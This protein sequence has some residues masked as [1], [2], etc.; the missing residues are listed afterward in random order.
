MPTQALE[1]WRL[2]ARRE[3]KMISSGESPAPRFKD[4]QQRGAARALAGFFALMLLLTLLSRAAEGLTVARVEVAQPKTGVLTQRVTVN[5]V[6][7]AQGDLPITLPGGIEVLRVAAEKGQRVQAGGVLLEL[8]QAGLESG[9]E[10]L[11][12]GLKLLDLRI[13]AARQGNTEESTDALLSAQEAVESAEEA[14]RSAEQALENAREDHERLVQSRETAESREAEDLAQAR[15]DVEQAEANLEKAKKK[16]KEELEK[17][18]KEKAEAARETLTG[19]EESAAEEK[20]AAKETLD[21]ASQEQSSA[22]DAYWNAIEARDRADRLV[23]EAQAAL[24]K[25]LEAEAPDEQTVAA[26]QAALSQA[27]SVLLQI[28]S[29]MGSLSAANDSAGQAL[30]QAQESL[31][32]VNEKWEKELGKAKEALEKAEAELSEVQARSDMSEE[33]LVVS[34]QASLDSARRALRSAERM[35]ADTQVSTEDQLRSSL[36]GIETAEQNVESARRN[37][38][39]A[40]RGVDSALRQMENQ[41]KNNENARRQAEIEE[42]G[43]LSQRRELEESIAALEQAAAAGGVVTAPISGT[44]FSILEEP[45][46]TQEG[47]RVALLSRSDLGFQ[48]TGKLTE[49]EAGKLSVGDEG[50]L[51]YQQDG[52][53][54]T[55]KVAITGI[56]MADE[57]GMVQVTVRLEGSYPTGVSASLEISKRS[58]QYSTCLP[59]SALRSG[60]TEGYFVLVMREKATVMGK[61]QT[62]VKVPVELLERDSKLAAVEGGMLQQGDRV[63]VTANKPV[64]EGDRVREAG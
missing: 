46:K 51:T 18:A 23:H 20:G 4:P 26:A 45:G 39:R 41:R 50:T 11:R 59:V 7:E 49:K 53:S 16:A 48:F 15:A 57:Q 62:A 37:L 3:K 38:E 58:E 34:A 63:I 40:E 52:K 9:L 32:K 5:G 55:A 8:D 42:L 2:E 17:A 33:P 64:T 44:L 12:N 27:Q 54:K 22:A 13:A 36:R 61:E 25:L 6:I 56:G 29:S 30:K 14:L 43:Y 35:E 31:K 28:E 60:G 24:D 1:K 47:A 10:K 19:L 21:T